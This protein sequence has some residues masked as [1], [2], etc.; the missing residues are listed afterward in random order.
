MTSAIALI[1][2]YLLIASLA[3]AMGRITAYK[4]DAP[5]IKVEQAFSAPSN[6]TGNVAGI[7]TETVP[8]SDNDCNGKIKGNISSS[9]KIYHMPGGAFYARTNPEM[10][11]ATEAEASAAGF[12]KSSR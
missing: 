8:A 12:R 9:G 7:Q 3:F 11:F 5:E 2:G 1:V 10:C 6:Y 4:Y